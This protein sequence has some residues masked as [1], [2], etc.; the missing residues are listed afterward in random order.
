MHILTY[1][2]NKRVEVFEGWG[3]TDK[4]VLEAGVQEWYERT[5]STAK[6]HVV[7]YHNDEC[8]EP[9][10][11]GTYDSP[12]LKYYFI[13]FFIEVHVKTYTKLKN[14]K[15]TEPTFHLPPRPAWLQR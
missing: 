4:A 15:V 6:G 5:K 1:F 2:R 7:F 9:S 3:A 10:E 12:S 13:S 8:S 11:R 14:V